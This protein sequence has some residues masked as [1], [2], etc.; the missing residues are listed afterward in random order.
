[1]FSDNQKISGR[2]LKAL[3]LMDWLG[4]TILLLP[5]YHR[6]MNFQTV[7]LGALA[8]SLLAAGFLWLV[9]GVMREAKGSYFTYVQERLGKGAA[10]LIYLVY[11][12]YFLT[13]L[14]LLLAFCGRLAKDNLLPELP[15]WL[16][17][18]LPAAT[19][20]YL[21]GGGLEVRGRVSELLAPVVMGFFLLLLIL[22]VP[23]IK[24]AHFMDGE[25]P[26]TGS[27]TGGMAFVPGEFLESSFLV[28]AGFGG[29][30]T[31]PLA[32][33]GIRHRKSFGRQ[34]FRAL[35]G[36][37]LVL[38]AVIFIGFG[39]FGIQ[40]M[41]RLEWPVISLMSGVKLPGVFL[42][43]WDV[44]F[45]ALLMISLFLAAGSG[46]YYAGVIGN[47][48]GV[49]KWIGRILILVSGF[50][51]F[52]FPFQWE[53]LL[54]WYRK[55][56]FF[57]CVP[58]MIFFIFLLFFVERIRSGKR[59][60]VLAGLLLLSAGILLGLTGCTAKDLEVRRFPLVLEIGVKEGRLEVA[61]A[62]PEDG[63]AMQEESGSEA[64]ESGSEA[65]ESGSEAQES[66]ETDIKET[67][68]K[69][70]E[71][72]E[73]ERI[74]V[75]GE[76]RGNITR[77]TAGGMEE[78]ILEIQALQDRYVDY[79][80]VKAILWQDSLHREEQQETKVL[81]WLETEPD[82]AR[83][84]LIFQTEEE[85][86]TLEEVQ[87]QSKGQPGAYLENLYQNNPLYQEK[88]GTLEQFLYAVKE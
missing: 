4:K 34:A 57:F 11:S 13:N 73:T 40:G 54:S 12:V 88:T 42:Q 55:I 80:H 5:G 2:Q 53:W 72:K 35:R 84:I 60:T 33:D 74:N 6:K 46:I 62:W 51:L 81:E 66:Q 32:L 49:P 71:I 79:S 70:T 3:L 48:F 20:I 7:M 28:L 9:C 26:Y 1:M 8:G 31:L 75:S 59:K 63:G 41:E 47:A 78:A 22:T 37:A 44:L 15:L 36:M 87:R 29:I 38:L 50:V 14:I 61:C 16:L 65:E 83:N 10:A 69:V 24:M 18:L 17:V 27:G 56:N 23:G 39:V 68:A 64:E 30:G 43:R 25:V 45:I 52:L 85:G 76:N 77:V 67:E 58:V 21:A 82:F 86:L 19:G